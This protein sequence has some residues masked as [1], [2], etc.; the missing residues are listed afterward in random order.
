[1]LYLSRKNVSYPG[2]EPKSP[3]IRRGQILLA[4]EVRGL[5][6]LLEKGALVELV[7]D[8]GLS[9]DDVPGWKHRASHFAEHGY[10]TVTDVLLIDR[11]TLSEIAGRKLEVIDRWIDEL[12]SYLEARLQPE[13]W[14]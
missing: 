14:C 3:T 4:N 2:D 7:I 11:A 6:R 10:Q 1:M 13:S 12:R 9:L 5:S 8:D